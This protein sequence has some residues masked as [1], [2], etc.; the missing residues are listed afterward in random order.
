MQASTDR[1]VQEMMVAQGVQQGALT[2]STQQ[3]GETPSQQLEELIK[4]WEKDGV[5]LELIIAMIMSNPEGV[6]AMDVVSDSIAGITNQSN[7]LSNVQSDVITLNSILSKIES[8]LGT[9]ANPTISKFPKS[10]LVQ[11]QTTY[12]KLFSS[13]GDLD[14]LSA[15]ESKFPTLQ[16]I[17]GEVQTFKNDF[18]TSL[19]GS[20]TTF[21]EDVNNWDQ[22]M[23]NSS[24]FI[25]DVCFLAS[26]HYQANH[27]DSSGGSSTVTDILQNWWTDGNAGQQLLS[28]QSQQNTTM[29]QSYMQLLQ[30]FDSSAQQDIQ[31]ASSQKAQI[32]QN[33]KTQ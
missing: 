1:Q 33:E 19:N 5:T 29:I 16:P 14:Q 13:G 9:K 8:Q 10:L 4:Q 20:G 15:L 18:N 6:G 31:L 25:K 3:A 27:P 28:G 11:F 2:P 21:D 32:I 7:I 23:N 26:Q 12:K 24:Q 17:I 22:K 30:G